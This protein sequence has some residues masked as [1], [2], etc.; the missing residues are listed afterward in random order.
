[1]CK[2]DG[3]E[4]ETVEAE[5]NLCLCHRMYSGFMLRESHAHQLES[6]AVNAF[7]LS[8]VDFGPSVPVLSLTS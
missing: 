3:Q 6:F 7:P 4:K 8:T 2:S 5:N 1:M